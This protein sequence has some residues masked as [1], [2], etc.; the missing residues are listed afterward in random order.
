MLFCQNCGVS[1]SSLHLT[2]YG[3]VLCEDCWKDY[4]TTNIRQIEHF[5]AICLGDEAINSFDADQLGSF[6][7]SWQNNK[8]RILV[9]ISIIETEAKKLGLLD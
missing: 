9:N 7:V 5:I 8:D 1:A 6:A 2:V 3:D 4:L